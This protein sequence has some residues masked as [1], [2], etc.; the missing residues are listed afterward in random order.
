MIDTWPGWKNAGLIGEGSFGRVYRIQREE[1][2]RVYEAA[3]KV[4]TIPGSQADVRAAYDEGMDEESVTEYF[5]GFVEEV[6]AEFALLS[7][8]KGNSNIVSY[9]DHMVV[10]RENEVGWDILIRME[11][12]T[13]LTDYAS[14]HPLE[15]ADVIRLGLDMTQALELCRRRGIVHRDIKPENI[16][17]SRDGNFKLGDF[18]VARVAEKTVSAMSRKGTYN[19]MAP[20]VYRG[21]EYGFAA[22]LY[23]LGLV[24]Y[25]F[26]ND[27]RTPFLPPYPEKIL[28]RDKEEALN[29]RMS[30]TVLP[31]PAHGS[32]AL[33]KVVA[34]ACAYHPGDRY[35]SAGEFGNAL[36]A[37]RRR[38]GGRSGGSGGRAGKKG[39]RTGQRKSGIGRRKG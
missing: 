18:G 26:L 7:E 38:T 19:Y 29:K 11:L 22:D 9:E 34:K 2:G 20:E 32:G 24:L 39:D 16:F 3:L 27:N 10:Q 8:L 21:E 31:P 13:A 35:G 33:K 14:A 36:R 4:I 17:I 37:V 30:G 5:R 6:V 15:E 23:S 28:Y 25:H 12:L 1:F